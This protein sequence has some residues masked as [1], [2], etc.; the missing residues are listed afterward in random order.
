MLKS[1]EDIVYM[2]GLLDGEG[3]ITHCNSNFRVTL[4]NTNKDILIWIRSKFGGY[5]NDQYLPK[6]P[7]HNVAWKWI[8]STKTEVFIFL[9]ELLP[10][11]KIKNK[12]A[13]LVIKFLKIYKEKNYSG[14]KSNNNINERQRKKKKFNLIKDKL[15]KLKTDKHYLRT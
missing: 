14:G 8:L 2:A 15:R 11:L 4:S 1:H 7:N 3:C 5:V 12:E 10:Y 9:E 13:L 6:N